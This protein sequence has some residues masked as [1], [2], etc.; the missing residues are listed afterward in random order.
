VLVR[1]KSPNEP[2]GRSITMKDGTKY[3]FRPNSEGVNV[4]EV[5]DKDHI[6]HLC[7]NISEGYCPADPKLAAELEAARNKKTEVVEADPLAGT[8]KVV[9]TTA[10]PVPEDPKPGEVARSGKDYNGL[11]RKELEAEY[12]KSFG[13][14]PHPQMKDATILKRL[15]G[16]DG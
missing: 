6:N 1:S 8:E 13:Q 12:E 7:G 14:K 11:T 10:E 5:A 4:C 15:V 16:E 2:K 3:D 9:D